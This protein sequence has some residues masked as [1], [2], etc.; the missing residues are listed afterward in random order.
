MITADLIIEGYN[1]P[2]LEGKN[3]TFNCR[4]GLM[5]IGPNSATCMGNG[6]WEPN[7]RDAICT[8]GGST[9]LVTTGTSILRNKFN[10]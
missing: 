6:E 4:E 7:P 5:L 1:D 9:G 10:A 3:I 2:A 8:G